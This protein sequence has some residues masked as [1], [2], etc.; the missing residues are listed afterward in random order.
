MPDNAY[1]RY[2]GLRGIYWYWLSRDVRESEW[3]KWDGLCLTC[4]EPLE[5]WEDGDCGHVVASA[6]C[7][8]Y[9]RFNR[10]NLTIQHKKCNNP[11]F[12]PNAGAMN[13]I[14]Y[15]QRYGQGAYERLYAMRKTEA[16]CPRQDEY[17]ELIKAIPAYERSKKT[18]VE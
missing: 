3:D 17:R 6:R 18:F 8:E 12:S 4:L 9:L 15:D 16:K 11:R 5:R 14:H 13:A 10:I 7:G 2:Q 1:H